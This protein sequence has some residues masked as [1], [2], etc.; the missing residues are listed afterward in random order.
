V[1]TGI[2]R[3]ELRKMV[4]YGFD[5]DDTPRAKKSTADKKAA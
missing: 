2:F 4:D 1:L 5:V 3:G